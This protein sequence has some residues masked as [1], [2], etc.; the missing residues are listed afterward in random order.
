MRS[1][2]FILAGAFIVLCAKTTVKDDIYQ[3]QG[4]EV[5][6]AIEFEIDGSKHAAYARRKRQAVVE[7][8]PIRNKSDSSAGAKRQA[9]YGQQNN[10]LAY[11]LTAAA[12]AKVPSNQ[13]PSHRPLQVPTDAASLDA[14]ARSLRHWSS[15]PQQQQQFLQPQLQP[16]LL[17]LQQAPLQRLPANGFSPANS[18]QQQALFSQLRQQPLLQQ[19]QEP[20]QLQQL[21]RPLPPQLS[22]ATA[23]PAPRTAVRPSKKGTHYYYP[24]RQPLPLPKCFHNPTGYVCCNEALNDLMVDTYTA[25]EQR[26][27]F[28][29]CNIQLIATHLQLNAQRHFNTSFET[30]VGYEDFAQKINFRG[31]L[32]CKV[33]LGSRYMIAYATASD[34]YNHDLGGHRRDKRETNGEFEWSAGTIDSWHSIHSS[35][36]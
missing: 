31:D 25:L 7:P 3:I 27:K 12:A 4:V 5:D 23:A 22:P 19:Q 29:A 2:V 21:P 30:L 24:P 35:F 11:D 13:R 28:H 15:F 8:A 1:L 32:V 14:H 33:E 17:Q 9:G 20:Q 18:L 16:Q 36:I 6:D 34:A 10:Q 26:P